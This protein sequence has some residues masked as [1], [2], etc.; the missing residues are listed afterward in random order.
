MP[1]YASSSA[2]P[3]INA[4]NASV[5]NDGAEGLNNSPSERPH[6]MKS[7]RATSDVLRFRCDRVRPSALGLIANPSTTTMDSSRL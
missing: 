7:S 5:S 3:G 4:W 6:R 1:R 2:S